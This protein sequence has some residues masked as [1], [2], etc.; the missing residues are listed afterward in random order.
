[1]MAVPHHETAI[2]TLHNDKMD[3]VL[4]VVCLIAGKTRFERYGGIQIRIAVVSPES[5]IGHNGARKL[6]PWIGKPQHLQFAAREP[7]C[8][9]ALRIQTVEVVAGT[10]RCPIRL[11]RAARGM[12]LWHFDRGYGGRA[13]ERDTVGFGKPRCKTRNR[14]LR[15]DAQLDRA[16]ENRQ[17]V[18]RSDLRA[19][20]ARLRRLEQTASR[21]HFRL[22]ERAQDIHGFRA[23]G[24]HPEARLQDCNAGCG[25][26]FSPHLA[27]ATRAC[28]H[29]PAFLPGHGDKTEVADRGSVRL[30]VAVDYDHAQSPP[31]GG[32][33]RGQTHDACAYDGEIKS[34]CQTRL[35]L[36]TTPDFEQSVP[37]FSLADPSCHQDVTHKRLNAA[38]FIRHRVD[39]SRM[40]AH[41]LRNGSSIA[42]TAFAS[43]AGF[44]AYFSMYAFRKPFTAASFDGVVG[45]H[46]ALDFKIALVLAQL[47]GYAASKFIGIKVISG[48]QRTYRAQAILGLIGAS[49]LALV[50]FAVVPAVFKVP[51]MFFNGLCL[52]MIWGLVFSYMEGRRTSEILGAVLCA[53]FI[54]S[55]GAVKSVGILLIQLVHV[56]VFWMPAATGL[57]FVPLLFLSVWGLSMLPPPSA[58]DEAARV[59]RAPM[60]GHEIRDFLRD[61]GVGI[62]LLVVLYVF[63]TALRDFRD[64]FAAELW[65]ALGYSDPAS[66]FTST[67]IVVAAVA[68]VAMGVVVKVRS[69]VRALAVIHGLIMAGLVLLG[70]ST[71]AFDAGWLGPLPWMIASG[72]GLYV[73][74]TPFNAM[75][76]D[77]MVAVSGR[78]ANAGFLIYVADASGYAGSCA[79]LLWRNFGMQH[80]EWLTVFRLSVYATTLVGLFLV[81]LSLYYFN[82]RA[83]M[84]VAVP[85]LSGA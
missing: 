19:A 65:T 73:V 22:H 74:Y 55:S 82:G 61:Y 56:P 6:E 8:A 41:W 53:S 80:V 3:A 10:Y 48:M 66:V 51:A 42:F 77:R 37:L 14:L 27:T 79:L 78:V 60:S 7:V 83:R 9:E 39:M 58:E 68:L 81:T 32:E 4:D 46:Y 29:R 64:N 15:L 17:R 36:I 21:G 12:H 72:A 13:Q 25:G 1:M 20:T 57:V 45:W 67:E 35:S 50:V 49:W 70:A 34:L 33:R 23:S 18:R 52:G 30:G 38:S 24:D 85:A 28:P 69:N 47:V 76:F 71:L 63:V 31:D 5:K 62:A 75:L 16:F 59:R 43:L 84:A 40:P 26:Y 2:R 44:T 11:H 54:V